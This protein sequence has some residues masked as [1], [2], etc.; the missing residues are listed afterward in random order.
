MIGTDPQV[1]VTTTT[2]S[3][4]FDNN[5]DELKLT[6]SGSNEFIYNTIGYHGN[7]IFKL[8][9]ETDSSDSA[10]Y[11]FTLNYINLPA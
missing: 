6:V 10:C 1:E 5:P 11:K 9:G 4:T 3:F 2:D 8:C 7:V